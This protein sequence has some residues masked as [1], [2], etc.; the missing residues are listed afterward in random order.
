MWVVVR[1]KQGQISKALHHLKQQDFTYYAPRWRAVVVRRRRKIAVERFLFANY[2][3][4]SIGPQWSALRSTY[5]VGAVLMNGDGP[6]EVPARVIGELRA[7]EGPDGYFRI[8]K[9]DA[10]F[11]PGQRLRVTGGLLEG[12]TCDFV[13]AL[14][15][16]RVRV[17][18]PFGLV[19]LPLRDLAAEEAS[20]SCGRYRSAHH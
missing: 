8:D 19:V 1:A 11:R 18:F 20:T 2:V 7:M 10:R 4:V 6:G 16:D 13:H 15:A 3:F 9:P 17:I 12:Q 5:G 14:G